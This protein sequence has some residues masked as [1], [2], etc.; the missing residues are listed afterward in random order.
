[1]GVGMENSCFCMNCNSAKYDEHLLM[2]TVQQNVQASKLL[3]P[4][5][6]DHPRLHVLRID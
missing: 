1:M 5:Y 3:S 4:V 2:F 6:W